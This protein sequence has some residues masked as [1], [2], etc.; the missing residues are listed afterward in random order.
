MSASLEELER[1]AAA[2]NKQIAELKVAKGDEFVDSVIAD[3]EKPGT[4]LEDDW[5][6]TKHFVINPVLKYRKASKR[7]VE[8]FGKSLYGGDGQYPKLNDWSSGGFDLNSFRRMM[9]AKSY[10]VH[11]T[12]RAIIDYM[13]KLVKKS[14]ARLEVLR[15]IVN[16][17]ASSPEAYDEPPQ[18]WS[19][20]EFKKATAN[21]LIPY[22]LERFDKLVFARSSEQAYYNNCEKVYYIFRVVDTDDGASLIKCIKI[23]TDL[24]F[25]DDCLPIIEED[26]MV[27]MIRY[28]PIPKD[29]ETKQWVA[30]IK[31]IVG[32]SHLVKP[33]ELNVLVTQCGSRM[34]EYSK[35]FTD[36]VKEAVGYKK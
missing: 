23:S 27:Q 2:I 25:R 29:D 33:C 15:Y 11:H 3:L 31:R 5:G 34:A 26:Y 8:F 35:T 28:Q 7:S 10:I 6:C 13:G 18:L 17:V 30:E 21:K 1:Q 24:R 36:T 32:E 12:P 16:S 4:Y 19:A 20:E 22:V 9:K 14:G